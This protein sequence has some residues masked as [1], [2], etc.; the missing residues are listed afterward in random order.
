MKK[1]P[2]KLKNI[3]EN[4]NQINKV[5]NNYMN[6]SGYKKWFDYS[7]EFSWTA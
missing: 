4:S 3:N 7:Q 6:I 1:S 2:V 5:V